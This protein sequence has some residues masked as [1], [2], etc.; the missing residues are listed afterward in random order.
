LS[1]AELQTIVD[2]VR[3]AIEPLV[4]KAASANT[5][6]KEVTFTNGR[7]VNYPAWMLDTRGHDLLPLYQ[8]CF[9]GHVL[10]NPAQLEK[11]LRQVRLI[12]TELANVMDKVQG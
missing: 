8:T 7:T 10:V 9:G 6:P 1:D 11:S 5:T 2:A 12:P 4:L 3:S